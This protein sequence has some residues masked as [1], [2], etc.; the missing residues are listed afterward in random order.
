MSSTPSEARDCMQHYKRDFLRA[1]GRLLHS[2][3]HN[4]DSK[5]DLT[6]ILAPS[7][8]QMPHD[9]SSMILEYVS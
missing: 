7:M 1:Q 2:F 4:D 5:V 6:S 8:D 9:I 3:T